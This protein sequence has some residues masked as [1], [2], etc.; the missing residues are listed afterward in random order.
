MVADEADGGEGRLGGE[1]SA[2]GYVKDA[3]A[4]RNMHAAKRA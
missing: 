1:P 4:E 3:H 2:C